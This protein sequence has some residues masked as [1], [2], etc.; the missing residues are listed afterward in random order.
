[1]TGSNGS[2]LLAPEEL[3]TGK[4]QWARTYPGI[5]G[6]SPDGRW[7]AIYRPFTPEL[8]V[9]RLPE[10]VR[11]AKLTHPALIG[12]FEFSPLG[13]EVTI[14][15]A[16]AG[17]EFWSTTTW[18][19]TRALTNFIRIL[20]APDPRALWLTKDLRTAGLYDAHTLEPRLL[21]PTRMRPL[22]VSPDGR[23]LAVS[24]D[25]R[26][27]QVLDLVEVRERFRELGLDWASPP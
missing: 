10:L 21:L 27:L 25:A 22:A 9:Y 11:V 24:V 18:T 13:D 23:H 8:Y 26:R 17:I 7:L 19:R 1:M 3:E 4:G 15:S 12:D 5:N 14:S 20:Y 6:V 2:Q 16:R